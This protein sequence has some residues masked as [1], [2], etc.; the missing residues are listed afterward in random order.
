[1]TA[2]AT[3]T[4]VEAELGRTLTTAEAA[5]VDAALDKASALVRAET[6]R[7]FEAGTY[8]VRRKV[9]RG[10]VVLDAPATV[11]SVIAVDGDGTVT[12]ITGAILRTEDETVYNLGCDRWV[13]ITY[14]TAGEVPAELVPV[15]AAL[16]AAN[17]TSGAPEGVQSYTVTKGPFS[18]SATFAEPTDSLAPTPSILSVIRRHKLRRPGPISSL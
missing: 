8:T 16:A 6:G 5:K 17:I 2:L 10:R 7:K 15:V 14:T 18:E 3:S 9:R 11:T 13:E 12:A 4:D 1:M